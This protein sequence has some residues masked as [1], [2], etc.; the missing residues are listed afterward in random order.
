MTAMSTLERF[1][2]ADRVVV[3]TGA[4]SGIGQ[5]LAIALADAG[6]DIVAVARGRS[7]LEKTAAQIRAR[8]RRADVCVFDLGGMDRVADAGERLSEPFGAPHILVNAAGVNDRQ[9]ADEVT[10]AQWRKAI[11]L[12][13]GVPFFLAQALVPGM[14]DQ[15][16]GRVLNIGSLQSVRAF[17]DSVPYGSAKGGIVQLTRAMAEAWSAQGINCNAI[18]PGFFRTPLT[19]AVFDDPARA[20]RNA[21]QTAIG[22]NGELTDLHGA[23]VFLTSPAA[24]YVTGQTLFV[25]GG[26][27]A[28]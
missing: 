23:A 21:A 15:G 9:S 19:E 11:E 26:F 3:V 25:D 5:S 7:G 24:D 13:L 20:E 2:L 28:K 8:G 1:S 6:A 12:N 4:S 22:R 18:A 10:P 16:W 27:T 14:I 17:P